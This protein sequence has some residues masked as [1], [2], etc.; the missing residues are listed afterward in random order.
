VTKKLF[1]VALLPLALVLTSAP[2]VTQAAGKPGYR[3]SA[4]WHLAPSSGGYVCQRRR[5]KRA[6][7]CRPGYVRKALRK[8]AV[9]CR[10]RPLAPPAVAPA[11]AALPV[12]IAPPPVAAPA[13]TPAAS[14]TPTPTP[15]PSPT[16]VPRDTAAQLAHNRDAADAHAAEAT[17]CIYGSAGGRA[18]SSCTQASTD[19][20]SCRIL[21]DVRSRCDVIELTRFGM[22]DFS[23]NSL[24]TRYR[25][26][27]P[28]FVDYLGP[29][30]YRHSLRDGDRAESTETVCSDSGVN[31]APPC[32]GA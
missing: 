15:T 25:S 10:K 7:T 22:E 24:V 6:P 3:C 14:P 27:V 18:W 2:T 16:P 29:G 1:I 9:R 19:P 8:K 31:G 20:A 32:G 4:G 30:Q 23:G 21:D 26:V 5:A 17:E 12:V 13:P 28:V 11:P